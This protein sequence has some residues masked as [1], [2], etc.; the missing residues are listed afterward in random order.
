[1]VV[2]DEIVLTTGLRLETD[3][4]LTLLKS[5]NPI[6][7]ALE[8]C[9]MEK[10]FIFALLA[11]LWAFSVSS[12]DPQCGRD[13]SLKRRKNGQPLGQ[14]IGGK[15]LL[16]KHKYGWLLNI[17]KTR[18]PTKIICGGALIA[19]KVAITAAHCV[20]KPRSKKKCLP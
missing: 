3:V 16:P 13:L 10:C 19:P 6:F 5:Q 12:K 8:N 17:R 9:K 2:Y 18:E 15:P 1:M 4:E 7:A 20:T 14:I 11:F